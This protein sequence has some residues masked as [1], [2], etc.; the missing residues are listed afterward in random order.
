[1]IKDTKSS[2]G[3]FVNNER[4][5]QT[6]EDSVPQQSNTGDIIQF[7]VKIVENTNKISLG[8]ILAMVRLF[9]ENGEEMESQANTLKPWSANQ[10]FVG[11]LVTGQQPTVSVLF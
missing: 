6:G 8:C 9:D 7:G 3:T 2:N 10:S 11:S 1:M 5:A 4:L